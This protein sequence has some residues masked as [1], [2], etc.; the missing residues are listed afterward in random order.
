MGEIVVKNLTTLTDAAALIHVALYLT[1]TE[2]VAEDKYRLRM[3]ETVTG[4]LVI[5]IR[6]RKINDPADSRGIFERKNERWKGAG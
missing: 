3:N 6:R 5:V 4:K 1:D 2:S